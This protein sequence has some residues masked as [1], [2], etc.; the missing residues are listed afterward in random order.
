MSNFCKADGVGEEVFD[1][2]D[3]ARKPA[4]EAPSQE[5]Q[6]PSSGR[7]LALLPNGSHSEQHQEQSDITPKG[8]GLSTASASESLGEAAQISADI[9]AASFYA[10][11]IH[12]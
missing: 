9:S 3:L 10:S 6:G 11:F 1:E 8:R 7:N 4:S 12:K 2:P 5:E